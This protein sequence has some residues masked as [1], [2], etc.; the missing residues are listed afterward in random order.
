V[1][2]VLL[3]NGADINKQDVEKCTPLHYAAINSAFA[4]IEVVVSGIKQ[5]KLKV[6]WSI[7]NY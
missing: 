7:K 1:V 4:V 3:E 2:K 5:N 6:D